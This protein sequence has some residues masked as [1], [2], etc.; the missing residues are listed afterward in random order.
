MNKSR[1]F[2]VI[3][4]TLGSLVSMDSLPENVLSA[5]KFVFSRLPQTILWKYENSYMVNKPKN[6]ILL[7][8]LPQ[9]DI[10]RKFCAQIKFTAKLNRY[11]ILDSERIARKVLVLQLCVH[12]FFLL[13]VHNF[14]I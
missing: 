4:F 9:R 5:F 1:E 13:S 10:L 3:V 7:S 14:S 2:G 8:W 11:Q 6:A 12:F